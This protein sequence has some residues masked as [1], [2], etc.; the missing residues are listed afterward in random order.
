ME[1]LDEEALDGIIGGCDQLDMIIEEEVSASKLLDNKDFK[2]I[3]KGKTTSE[4]RSKVRKKMF[5]I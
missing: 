1:S 2:N 4:R 3:T 5:N